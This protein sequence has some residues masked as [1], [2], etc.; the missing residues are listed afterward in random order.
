MDLLV[1]KFVI[2]LF[3]RESETVERV[4]NSAEWSLKRVHRREINFK[5][6]ANR[7]NLIISGWKAKI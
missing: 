6:V 3:S 2:W 5:K 7:A 4:C 1:I